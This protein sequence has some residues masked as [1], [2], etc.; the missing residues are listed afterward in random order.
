M[1]PLAVTLVVVAP[2]AGS[3][4]TAGVVTVVPEAVAPKADSNPSLFR[5]FTL[6]PYVIP[7][8]SPVMGLV[9]QPVTVDHTALAPNVPL[10]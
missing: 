5:A 6:N 9:P 4:D 2:V 7:V 1:V 10:A 8:V 3:V